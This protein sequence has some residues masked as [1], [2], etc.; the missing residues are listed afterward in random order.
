M[1][2]E[3]LHGLKLFLVILVS[4]SMVC[5]NFLELNSPSLVCLNFY[6]FFRIL[7]SC[8]LSRL[9]FALLVDFF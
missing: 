2:C 3:Y 6:E 1:F 5:F 7:F 8:V 4:L 9:E